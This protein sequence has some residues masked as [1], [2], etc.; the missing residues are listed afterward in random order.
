MITVY[1]NYASMPAMHSATIIF[2][3]H[4]WHNILISSWKCLNTEKHQM[5]YNYGS[6][7]RKNKQS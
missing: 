3:N 1:E 6:V 7:C 4:K 5:F 2:L